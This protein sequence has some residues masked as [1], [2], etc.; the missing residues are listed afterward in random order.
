MSR[1]SVRLLRASRRA[2]LIGGLTMVIAGALVAQLF[3]ARTF[4]ADARP[5]AALAAASRQLAITAPASPLHQSPQGPSLL[6]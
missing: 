5:A 1:E 4:H 6:Y 2:L 3:A